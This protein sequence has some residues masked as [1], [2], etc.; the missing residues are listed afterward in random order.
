MRC[1]E[2]IVVDKVMRHSGL[3]FLRRLL[4]DPQ[5]VW[6]TSNPGLAGRNGTYQ[7][8]DRRM[9]R[10]PTMNIIKMLVC[11]VVSR[12]LGRHGFRL[13]TCFVQA[14]PVRMWGSA[15][16]PPSQTPHLDSWRKGRSV[17][18]PLFTCVIYVATE[19]IRGGNLVGLSG[20]DSAERIFVVKPK[21]NRL[22]LMSGRQWHM[23]DPLYSGLRTSCVINFY[24]SLRAEADHKKPLTPALDS[25]LAEGSTDWHVLEASSSE[26]AL[27]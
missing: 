4:D 26:K 24:K 3:R 8:I 15:L 12:E 9:H 25:N 11:W 17:H 13:P 5:L 23:V 19:C 1:G 10:T 27:A 20:S 2:L 21:A 6:T 14:F 16:L 22:V 7:L 18:H